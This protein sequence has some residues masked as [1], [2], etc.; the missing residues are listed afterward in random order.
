PPAE[1]LPIPDLRSGSKRGTRP[2]PH[3]LDTIY[4]CQQRQEWFRDYARV[5]GEPQLDFVGSLTLQ[6]SPRIAAATIR[7]ALDFEVNQRTASTVDDALRTFIQRVEDL[8]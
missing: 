5:T 3:L 2:S 7:K 8:G 6:T 4:I 1:P